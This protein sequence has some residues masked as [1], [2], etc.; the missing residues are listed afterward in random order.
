MKVVQSITAAFIASLVLPAPM[1]QAQ[2]GQEAMFDSHGYLTACSSRVSKGA[3]LIPML[4]LC[5]SSAI[6]LCNLSLGPQRLGGCMA[7]TALWLEH[8]SKRIAQEYPS[9][10]NEQEEPQIECSNPQVANLTSTQ[11]CAYQ[12]ALLKWFK[13]RVVEL[14]Q[15]PRTR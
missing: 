1:L 8:D 2:P 4:R 13:L 11:I 9:A 3:M 6:K 14:D 7:S 15:R 12:M 10:L 5:V